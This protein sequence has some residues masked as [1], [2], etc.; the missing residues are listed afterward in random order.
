MMPQ[1]NILIVDDDKPLRLTLSMVLKKDGYKTH[2]AENAD[3]AM[4]MLSSNTYDLAFLD[5]NMP[6]ISGVDLLIQIHRLYPRLPV[7]ILTGNAT[8]DTAIQAVRLGA[9]DYLSKPFEP[10]SLLSRVA[11][12]LAA[13]EQPLRKRG[14]VDQIQTLV[15][16][17]NHIEGGAS[18]A[19]PAQTQPLE[20]ESG[21][22]KGPF[23]LDPRHRQVTLQG[24]RLAVTGI[25][26]DYLATLIR[27][28]PNT[29]FFKELVKEAQGLDLGKMEAQNLARWRIHEL[30]KLVEKNPG[31]PTYILTVRGEGFRLDI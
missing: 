31:E 19:I 13:E 14:I 12:I 15:A 27:H 21:I 16:E 3:E 1:K 6:G 18:A 28:A 2:L 4:L 10:R 24:E 26:Y 25:S 30:R 17:L 23:V 11:E 22:R 5:L 9:R 8:L 20:A 29:V 7:L